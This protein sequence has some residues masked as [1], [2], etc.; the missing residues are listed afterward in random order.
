MRYFRA[1]KSLTDCLESCKLKKVIEEIE[2][3]V[4]ELNKQLHQQDLNH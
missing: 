4:T 1:Q 2:K 3:D